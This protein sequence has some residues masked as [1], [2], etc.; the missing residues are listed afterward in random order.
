MFPAGWWACLV[1]C[2]ELLVIWREY[3]W[4]HTDWKYQVT[5]ACSKRVHFANALRIDSRKTSFTRKSCACVFLAGI[6]SWSVDSIHSSCV[7]VK[8]KLG[9]PDRRWKDNVKIGGIETSCGVW[10]GFT[11]PGQMPGLWIS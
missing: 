4:T 5:V 8:R 7:K 10:A 2:R 3:Y 6:I 1:L 9:S 11:W